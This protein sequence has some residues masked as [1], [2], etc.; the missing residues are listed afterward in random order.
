MAQLDTNGLL[1][2]QRTVHALIRGLE[3]ELADQELSA[4]ETNL[5]A[6][7]T[8]TEPRRMKDLIEDTAQRPSTVTG[9]V[10]RLERRR[11][12][13]RDVDPRDRRSFQVRLTPAGLA[14]RGRVASAYAAIAR[15]CVDELGTAREPSFTEVL[16]ALHRTTR[17]AP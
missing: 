14:T 12:V 5:I 2:L 6:C 4:S 11:L 1:V 3:A 9:V 10:D 8:E 13:E 7:L 17:P 16:E 15:R